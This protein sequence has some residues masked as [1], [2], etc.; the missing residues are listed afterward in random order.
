MRQAGG[1]FEQVEVASVDGFQV[2]LSQLQ[3]Q[4]QLQPLARGSRTALP[5]GSLP[6]GSLSNGYIQRLS[7][8]G[9][10]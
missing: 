1:A 2:R 8:D 4:L 10:L 9:F 7:F 5:D 3:L 6:N